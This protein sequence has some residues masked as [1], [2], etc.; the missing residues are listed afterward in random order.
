MHIKEKTVNKKKYKYLVK[1]IRLPNGQ[2]KKIEKIYKGEPKKEIEKIL[3]E[4]ERKEYARYMLKNFS[5]NH[6]FTEEEFEKIED[7]KINYRKVIKKLTK[8]TLRDLLD[9]FTANFTYE[10]NAL[11]G[12]SLTL[13]N[14]AMIMFENT[15][16][17][18]KDLRE[19]YEQKIYDF[20]KVGKNDM[21]YDVGASCGEYAILCAKNGAEC[22]AF[23]LREDAFKIMHKN[24]KLNNFGNKIKVYLEKIDDKN[25]LD[26]YFNKTKKAPTLIKIDIE[27]DEL[28]ALNG[29]IKILKKYHPRIILETHSK[30]LERDCLDFLFKF[31]YRIKY[32]KIF[33]EKTILFFLA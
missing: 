3:E 11:E 32:K 16:I 9:R 18:G 20:F 19:I 33:N 13:K 22:L 8:S 14:V 4:K 29:S 28:K 1:S 31:N 12:N 10:S 30:E 21:V 24:I 6:I 27:G 17:R 2:I 26:F 23:E 7:I 25:T 5:T 15:T